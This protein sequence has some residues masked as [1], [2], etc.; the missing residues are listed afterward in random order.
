[1]RISPGR[2]LTAA[3]RGRFS[4]QQ[5]HFPESHWA[6]QANIKSIPNSL[7]LLW[8]F[9]VP[10]KLRAPNNCRCYCLKSYSHST[11]QK[12][13]SIYP[14]SWIFLSWI[15]RPFQ[16]SWLHPNASYYYFQLL[17]LWDSWMKNISRDFETLRHLWM[18]FTKFTLRSS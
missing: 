4:C 17:Y 13:S 9:R 16:V 7:Y 14:H 11:L 12:I 3:R 15:L 10:W 5:I 18:C 1:M 2:H 8:K 6:S